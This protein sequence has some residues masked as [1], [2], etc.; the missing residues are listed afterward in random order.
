MATGTPTKR[1]RS[2]STRTGPAT[3]STAVTSRRPR[4]WTAES[5][6]DWHEWSVVER[7]GWWA[8]LLA[9]FG[10]PTAFFKWGTNQFDLPKLTLLWSCSWVALAGVIAS[11]RTGR[12]DLVRLRIRWA[13]AAF[14]GAQVVATLLSISPRLSLFGTYGRYMGLVPILLFLTLAFAV[15]CYCAATPDLVRHLLF[16]VAASTIVG[17]L[18]A[19]LEPLGLDLQ[20]K[21]DSNYSGASVGLQ[22]NSDFS[23]GVIAIGVPSLLYL[24]TEA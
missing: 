21:S 2:R 20:F 3:R 18:F 7:L 14:A 10:V 15:V 24:R 23:A 9:A 16:A 19:V 12:L 4:H 13:I 11:V 22:G 5:A 1:A 17:C 8:V 6:A